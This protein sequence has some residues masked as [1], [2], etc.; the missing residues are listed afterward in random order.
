MWG[1]WLSGQCEELSL[2]ITQLETASAGK[3]RNGSGRPSSVADQLRGGIN[4]FVFAAVGAEAH[5]R[6]LLSLSSA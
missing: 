5:A 2:A 6:T 1:G 4:S 3:W